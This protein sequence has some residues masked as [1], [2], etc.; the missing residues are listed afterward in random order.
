MENNI[1]SAGQVSAQLTEL[2]MPII[3]ALLVL[4][5]TMWFKDFATS[6]A[7][8]LK[9]KMNRAFN[10]GDKVIL[11]GQDAIIVKIG[12]TE[13]VFGIYSDKGYTWRFVPNER[14]TS[15]RLEKVIHK[16]LQLIKENQSD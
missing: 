5:I 9:F 14:I 13:S 6:I 15:L 10:E 2:A 11:D 3:A 8:G 12:L 1:L 7:K 16:D 4:V